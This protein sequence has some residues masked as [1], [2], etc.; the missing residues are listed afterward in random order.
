[1]DNKSLR[2]YEGYIFLSKSVR[3]FCLD[4]FH[5]LTYITSTFC[6]GLHSRGI[7]VRTQVSSRYSE[8]KRKAAFYYV[9]HSSSVCIH[10]IFIFSSLGVSF[11]QKLRAV[12]YFLA[13]IQSNSSTNFLCYCSFRNPVQRLVLASTLIHHVCSELLSQTPS[14]HD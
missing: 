1:M 3:T 4:A 11:A 6:I 13:A 2:R 7:R 5:H 9:L 12:I 10:Q 14:K 8:A